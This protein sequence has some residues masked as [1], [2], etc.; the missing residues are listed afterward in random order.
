MS[1]VPERKKGETPQERKARK[2][3]VKENQKAA[4][5]RKKE[6]K[7]MYRREHI[8]QQ[9]QMAGLATKNASTV[10]L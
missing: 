1:T 9:K 8:K 7:M 10:V 6:L 3:A 5:A 2:A 4:R